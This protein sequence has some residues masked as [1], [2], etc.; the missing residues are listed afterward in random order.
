MKAMLLAAGKGTRVRPVT[1]TVPKPMIPIVNK[2]VMEFLIDL[3][4]QHGFDQ[5]IV[6]TSYLAH[7]IE[8]YF[9][10]GSR[11][12]VQIAYS[13]EGHHADGQVVPGGFG[14][15]GGL[16]KIQ[17]FSGFFDETFAVLCGD[18]L[19][20]VDL[21]RALAFHRDRKA[22]ATV[23]LKDVPREEVWKYGVVKTEA[24][25]RIVQFQEKPAPED[26]VSTTIN[27][28]IYFFEPAVFDHIPADTV[29][30]IGGQLLPRLADQRLPFYG[31]ALPFSW[32]DIGSTPDYWQATQMILRGEFAVEMPGR[33]LAPGIWGGINLAVDLTTCDVRAPVYLGS[34]TT[35]EPGA[36]VV[37]PTVI[38][39]N[40]LIQA[41][42][43]LDACVV[44]D[45]TR[46]SGFANLR[47]KIVSGRFCVDRAGH[48]VELAKTGYAFAVDDARER[49]RRV[50]YDASKRR[51]STD[52]DEDRILMEFLASQNTPNV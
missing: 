9:R 28:G 46:V 42:A 20:D 3:L 25:G 29:F 2:P 40:C 4:R 10:D 13:F 45:Y 24:D 50:V 26:A 36:T 22:L 37:G 8:H 17:D 39:H 27:T 35:I 34:S 47:E 6:S 15:A 38:G 12:G 41:G 43:R 5:I 48:N 14:S 7:E 33:E 49:R 51:R 1:D 32:I 44:G 52:T 11:F 30:D 21:T 23:V 18:A 31:V 16:K 19:I